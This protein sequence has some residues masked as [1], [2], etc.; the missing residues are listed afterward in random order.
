MV[1]RLRIS[2]KDKL[3]SQRILLGLVIILIIAVVSVINPRFIAIGNIFAI[4]QQISVL[5]ILTMAM[6]ILLIGG[7]VD[8]SVGNMMILCGIVMSIF[9]KNNAGTAASITVCLI[10]GLICGL[11]NGL[12]IAYSRCIP[13]II[14]LGSSQ[15]FYGLAL[16][17]CGGQVMSFQ[18]RL[19]FIGKTRIFDVFPAMLF[20]L[21]FV[22]LVSFIMM[23]YTKFG[24]WVVTIGSNE[25]NAFMSGIN[26]S[27]YKIVMY[28]IAGILCAVAA[29]IFSSRID[30]ITANAGSGYETRALTAAI[31][32]GITFEGGRGTIPGAF[33]GCLFMGVLSNAMSILR[34]PAYIQTM[35]TGIIVV[36]AVVISNINNLKKK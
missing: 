28:S 36:A 17:L 35:I 29:V 25:Q 27:R 15:V 26:V 9:I 11:V 6:G 20:V 16:T 18:G 14:T 33:L 12:I 22:V 23:N 31:I 3:K 30:S 13:L 10:T 4:F 2:F 24:R 19:N 34:V 8:L 1:E 21:M 32:G 5:G 7:G